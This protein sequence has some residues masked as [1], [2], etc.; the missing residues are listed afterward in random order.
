[1]I[2]Y[3]D[4]EKQREIRHIFS[5]L[6]LC[7]CG[8]SDPY[9]IINTLLKHAVSEGSFYDPIDYM[10]S[11]VVEFVAKVMNSSKWNLLEHGGSIGR[12][13]LTTKGKVLLQFFEDF[14]T[15][16]DEWPMWW[17]SCDAGEEW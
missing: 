13:W 4:K 5:D 2:D 16:T 9:K 17:C 12:S 11:E 6:D 14:G 8:T 1:M 3:E 7:G 10:S 15:D